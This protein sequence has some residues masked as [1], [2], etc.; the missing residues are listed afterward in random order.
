VIGIR[1]EIHRYFKKVLNNRY[2]QKQVD[3]II[4]IILFLKDKN[5]LFLPSKMKSWV[6]GVIT[7]LK[8][9]YEFGVDRTKP[10]AIEIQK[11][12]I[13]YEK[14]Q[15]K[16]LPETIEIILSKDLH[17]RCNALPKFIHIIHQK[18]YNKL[19]KTI[20]D[21]YNHII[22]EIIFLTILRYEYMLNSKNHQLG[23]DYKEFKISK[24]DIELF[25]SPMNRTLKEFCGAF[26]DIDK[27]YK[28]NLGSFFDFKLI[29][30]KKYTANPP[31]VEEIMS[32][33]SQ[34]IKDELDRNE[35][36]GIKIVVTIPV[37]DFIIQK[38]LEDCQKN[39]IVYDF[40]N[41][42]E[43]KPYTVLRDS[44]YIRTLTIFNGYNFKYI[45]YS[46]D[47]KISIGAD[48]FFLELEKD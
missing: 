1:H 35:I 38:I 48:T 3:D 12:F 9:L 34:K 4:S 24:F 41:H 5:D 31:Y 16:T 29:S 39:I 27:Y 40:K 30:N 15:Y 45:N 10:I 46:L 36:H 22:N 23:L 21:E 6:D 18:M 42:V 32:K 43:Y 17:L 13:K 8:Y 14:K 37:W 26:P 44:K 7:K 33:A 25:A 20:K 19:S 28:G 47:K 11:I 2:K